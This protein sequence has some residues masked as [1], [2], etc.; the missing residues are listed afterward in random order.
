MG[1]VWPLSLSSA[2]SLSICTCTHVCSNTLDGGH[3]QGQEADAGDLIMAARQM[4]Q[5]GVGQ[6]EVDRESSPPRQP[7]LLEQMQVRAIRR[8]VPFAHAICIV[9]F[10]IQIQIQILLA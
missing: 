2:L 10:Q 3:R 9:S 8:C 7:T 1:W 4:K 5:H 6:M